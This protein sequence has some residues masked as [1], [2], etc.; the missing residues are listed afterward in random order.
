MPHQQYDPDFG[1]GETYP[2]STCSILK[3]H[4]Q[5][6]D[7]MS[8]VTWQPSNAQRNIGSDRFCQRRTRGSG[9]KPCSKKMNL[10]L[11]LRTRRTPRIAS[12]TRGMVH[13]VNVLTTVS[14]F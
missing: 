7:G 4:L 6:R 8:R 1:K 12:T 11:G 5:M 9:D 2:A 14:T 10:P 13:N 3:P